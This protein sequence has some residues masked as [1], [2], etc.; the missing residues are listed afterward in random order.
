MHK[1]KKLVSSINSSTLLNIIAFVCTLQLSTSLISTHKTS[2]TKISH[3]KT[4]VSS[5]QQLHT[6]SKVAFS[7][8]APKSGLFPPIIQRMVA[9]IDLKRQ[10]FFLIEHTR[11]STYQEQLHTSKGSFFFLQLFCILCNFFYNLRNFDN[12]Y[13]IIS[14]HFQ[15]TL[16]HHKS[17]LLQ[18]RGCMLKSGQITKNKENYKK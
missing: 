11:Y 1:C 8:G 3:F 9:F 12:N 14:M 17:K 6:S 4:F 16:N 18:Q 2:I 5:R 7:L 15:T 10:H 13:Q